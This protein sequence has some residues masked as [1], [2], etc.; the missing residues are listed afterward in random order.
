MLKYKL[1]AQELLKQ[2]ENKTIT[3]K[4]PTEEQLIKE[5]NVSRNTIR[6]AI[7]YLVKESVLFSIQGSGSFVRKKIKDGVIP[8]NSTTGISNTFIRDNT[9]S[10]VL[11]INTLDADV[12][13]ANT[14]Q[15]EIGTM[16]YYIK[17]IRYL[18]DKPYAIERAY[19]NK[20]FIPYIGT[21][22]ATGSI[23]KYVLEDLKLSIGFSDKYVSCNKLSDNDA[24]HLNLNPGDPCIN[25]T[26]NVYL[27]NGLLFNSSIITYNYLHADFY[28]SST[29]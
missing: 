18:N 6:N 20:E 12:E 4:L 23:F 17:R 9:Y 13:L 25:V 11:V 14:M 1:V 24:R 26:D 27:S 28:I 2:I 21:E 29:N 15:C 5:Y 7:S 22:I 8:L 16:L 3:H 19:Y 10:D